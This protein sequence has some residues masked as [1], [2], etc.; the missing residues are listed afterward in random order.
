MFIFYKFLK[1]PAS[2][3]EQYATS[4]ALSNKL[5]KYG[6]NPQ[7]I[8]TKDKLSYVMLDSCIYSSNFKIPLSNFKEQY[9][10][11]SKAQ[12]NERICLLDMVNKTAE[13]EIQ[14]AERSVCNA[15]IMAIKEIKYNGVTNYQKNNLESRLLMAKL[16]GFDTENILYHETNQVNEQAI[17]NEGFDL[18]FVDARRSD[19][20]M[21]DGVFL[22]PNNERIGVAKD[23]PIQMPF[24]IKK[25]H[26]LKFENRE[27]LEHFLN[28][29]SEYKK[30]LQQGK[31][32]NECSKKIFDSLMKKMTTAMIQQGEQI[33]LN[34]K[35]S[36]KNAV[37]EHLD[38]WQKQT[39]NDA[40]KTRKIG[41]EYIKKLGYD[42]IHVKN[43]K[44]SWGREIE[45]I[46][47]L[48][49]NNLQ[50]T[51]KDFALKKNN[52]INLDNFADFSL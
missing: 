23:N 17:L 43:D 45:T 33:N 19:S 36:V 10:I 34:D 51:Q 44:G 11:I 3:I 37:K 47:V 18:S 8:L 30:S 40:T 15:L 41:T 12:M 25:G 4:S 20:I 38:N 16:R 6:Y 2:T 21:P 13:N 24:F 46:V 31:N 26:Y 1:K 39:V 49:P 48:D 5:I 50:S 14:R 52:E 22:K 35:N 29:S 32:N 42:G 28:Q 9:T 27:D 7:L